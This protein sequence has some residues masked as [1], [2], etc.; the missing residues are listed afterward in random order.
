MSL[1]YAIGDVHGQDA[2]LARLH[3]RIVH[4]PQRGPGA[5][6]P[7]VIHLGDYIDRGPESID[8][9]DRLM[10]GSPAFDSLALK[11]NHETML[12]DC[13]ASDAR[14]VWMAWLGNGG[15][16]TL[17]SLRYPLRAKGYDP[18]AL[19]EALGRRRIDW[20]RALPIQ[21][22]VGGHLFVHAGIVPGVPLEDQRPKDML[23][24]RGRF[25]DSDVD[26]GVV[27]VHGHTPTEEPQLRHNRIGVDTS[28]AWPRALTAVVLDANAPPRFM[29][30]AEDR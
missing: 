18:R 15:D 22:R 2:L 30:V 16:R 23:W 6:R 28:A 13:L 3:A 20:L 1:I 19:G 17:E 10:R 27:V 7:T 26:H 9:I 21:H 25:L 12:L 29:Q 14:E 4:D 24:I 11:G 8:V 5:A